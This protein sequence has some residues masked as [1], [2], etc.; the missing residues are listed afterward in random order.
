MKA[1]RFRSAL[2]PLVLAICLA[3][4]LLPGSLTAEVIRQSTSLTLSPHPRLLEA[5]RAPQTARIL[6]QVG[7][8]YTPRMSERAR[9]LDFLQK[10]RLAKSLL[11]VGRLVE[12]RHQT[13]NLLPPGQGVSWEDLRR[14]RWPGGDPVGVT[15]EVPGLGAGRGQA[16]EDLL[17]L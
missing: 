12:L 3:I 4:T 9:E 6:R 8:K 7:L 16:L 2:T 14:R 10:V 1:M 17:R 13:L 11:G 5:P 15:L